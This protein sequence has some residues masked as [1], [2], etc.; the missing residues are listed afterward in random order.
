MKRWTISAAIVFA[1]AI[2]AF[3]AGPAPLSSLRAIHALTNP[4]ASH[5]LPVNFEA[6]VTYFRSYERTLFVEDEDG[7]AI[8]VLPSFDL[9]LNPGDRVLIHGT[10]QPSFRPYV[11]ADSITR[12]GRAPLPKAV[13]ATFEELIRAEHDCQLVTVRARVRTADLVASSNIL[14]TSVEMTAGGGQIDAIIDSSD[15]AALEGLLDADVEVTGVVSGRF[16]GKMQQTGILLHVSSLSEVKVNRRAAGSPWSIPVTPMDEILTGFRI[17]DLSRR[18]RV[19]G[20]I[21]YYEPGS[22]LVLQNGSRSLWIMT[23]SEMPLRIGNEAEAIGFPSVRDGFLTL[24]G[25]EIQQVGEY[26]PIAPQLEPWE[27][28]VSSRHIFDLVSIDAR[29]VAAVRGASQDEYVLSADN[30][31]FS[32]IWRHP[33][34]AAADTPLPAMKDIPLGSQVR[35]TGICMLARSNPFNGQVPFDILMRSFDDIRV[36]AR[37]SPFNTRNLSI[38]ITVLLL[39]F[40]AVAGWG[41]I[42]KRKV[43]LQTSVLAAKIESEAALERRMARLEQG[44]SHILE[45]INGAKP[46]AEILEE[47]ASLESFRLNGAHCWCEVNGGARLGSY[48]PDTAK[49]RIVQMQIPAR[50]GPALGTLYAGIDRQQPESPAE[51][52]ALSAGTKLAALAIETRRLYTDLRHRSEFDL[53]TD[54]HNRFSLE[55]RLTT[56]IEETREKAGVFG[57]VYIDLDHFKQVNDLYGHRVGD[58]Y[59]QEVASRMKRQLRGGDMIARLGGDEFAAL[60]PQVGNRTHAEEIAQRLER[61]FDEPFHVNGYTLRGS[62]S[63]GIAMYPE[64]G[65]NKDSLL[66][67]ADAGMYVTKYSRR[68]IEE[69]LGDAA[70]SGDSIEHR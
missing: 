5:L 44:R 65:T 69:T 16:D 59:L 22:M 7:T 2:S 68:N 36:T 28:L 39:L 8:Y 58:L 13:P 9:Q 26:A 12:I 18:V 33:S 31:L 15:R 32:A 21:T 30:Q 70:E 57:L 55:K 64:D 29:V 3:A 35:V 20:T 50:S 52:E 47:V 38:A 19:R 56:L 41:W 34:G 11:L 14:S 60:L 40:L 6:T 24:T 4:E 61:S 53:L 10:T 49:V 37:P 62:A 23:Q 67:A 27:L 63:V 1:W 25:G 46:L 66:S 42:L 51:L 48:P 43:R 17:K 54:I 45:D